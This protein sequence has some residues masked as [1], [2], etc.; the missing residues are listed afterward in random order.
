MIRRLALVTVLVTSTIASAG[1]L[2]HR[3]GTTELLA[4]RPI[5]RLAQVLHRAAAGPKGAREGFPGTTFQTTESTNFAVKWADATITTAQAQIVADGLEIAWAKYIDDLGHDPCTGCDTFKLNA[6]IARATDTPS[7][8]Y[9]GGYAWVDDAGFP[10]FVISRE[11]F[12][13]PDAAASV[14][15]VAVHEFYHDI[16]FSTGAFVW[17][18]TQYGWFWEATAEWASQEALPTASDPFVFSGAFALTS[19]LPVYHY[20]DPFGADAVTGVHQ[21]GAAIFWRYLTDKLSAPSVIVNTWEQSTAD[22]EPLAAVTAQLPSSDLV[23]IHTEF[24]ARN[25]IWDY[26]YRQFI[27]DS[28]DLYQ[29]AFPNLDLIAARVPAAGVALTPLARSP[30]GF[31]Y[32]TIEIAR[33]ATGRFSAEIEIASPTAQVHGTLVYGAPGAATYTPLETTGQTAT[34]TIDLPAGVDTAYLVVSVTTDERLTGSAILLSYKVTPLEPEPEPEA[35]GCCDAG[36][37]PRGA[38]VLAFGAIVALRRR[39]R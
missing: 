39:R 2:D 26:P 37:N 7:I 19:E 13:Q 25:S 14:Q 16:Q 23:T 36:T 24:A 33:P 30:Y 1:P 32:S 35:G 6:Y 15:A 3:C 34:A 22:A 31:G 17:D 12:S 9:A 28:I 4:T 8:D 11:I 20:G 10:Y 5:P 29:S 18:T 27:L 21:Y 38:M